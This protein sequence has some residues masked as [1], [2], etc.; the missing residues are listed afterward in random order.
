MK[1][2]NC[3]APIDQYNGELKYSLGDELEIKSTELP[4]S[5]NNG[6]H[7]RVIRIDR[8]NYPYV[9]SAEY[10]D[11]ESWNMFFRESDLTNVTTL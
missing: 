9:Y 1:C 2:E 10:L 5:V 8:S 11:G 7:V 6:R 3:G 4:H